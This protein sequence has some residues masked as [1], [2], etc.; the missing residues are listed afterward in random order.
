MH[1]LSCFSFSLKFRPS[2]VPSELRSHSGLPTFFADFLSDEAYLTACIRALNPS[3]TSSGI[4][5]KAEPGLNAVSELLPDELKLS[6]EDQAVEEPAPASPD[7][8]ESADTQ[9]QPDA[10]PSEKM[11][12]QLPTMWLGA[13]NGQVFV[14]SSKADWGT[15]VM[16]VS[17]E[18]SE[19]LLSRAAENSWERLRRL[20]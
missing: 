18:H 12:T 10:D 14:H 4:V 5:T 19:D 15:C 13:Q 11:S 8:P 2:I 7:L 3:E 6:D 1:S 9:E 16:K 20:A 17:P